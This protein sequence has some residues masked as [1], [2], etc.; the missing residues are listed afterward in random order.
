MPCHFSPLATNHTGVFY[1]APNLFILIV[2]G[3][4]ETAGKLRAN[5]PVCWSTLLPGLSAFTVDTHKY[6]QTRQKLGAAQRIL[7]VQEKRTFVH[8]F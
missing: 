8:T 3:G 2:L 4:K 1:S 5:W 6:R 7:A